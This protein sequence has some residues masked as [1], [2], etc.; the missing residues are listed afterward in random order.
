[1]LLPAGLDVA[2]VPAHMAR[3]G[4]LPSVAAVINDAAVCD[5]MGDCRGW[6]KRS[7]LGSFQKKLFNRRQNSEGWGHLFA[8]A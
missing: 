5:R 3:L 1:M 2:A 6:R 7:G 8:S 4:P